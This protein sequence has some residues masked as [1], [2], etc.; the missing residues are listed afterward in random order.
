MTLAIHLDLLVYSL[1]IS[2]FLLIYITKNYSFSEYS[3]GLFAAII[4]ST[5]C[6]L[7][8]EISTWL[9]DGNDSP[10]MRILNYLTNS[11][12]TS[13]EYIPGFFW[14]LYFDYKIIDDF[15]A[16][17]KRAPF[18]LLPGVIILGIVL[19]SLRTGFLFFL[20][21]GNVYTRGPGVY[22]VS[23]IYYI[24]YIIAF[25]IAVRH[26]RNVNAELVLSLVAYFTLPLLAM[27]LQIAFY[28]ATLIWPMFTLVNLIAFI[29]L[30]KDVMLRDPLTGIYTRGEF[31]QKVFRLIKAKKPFTLIMFDLD[32]FKEINDTYGH[33]AGDDA[34]I[35]L[36][37]LVTVE[38]RK[39]DIFCRYG[40]DEF[41]ILMQ[42]D[43]PN[44]GQ[45]LKERIENSVLIRNKSSEKEY[46]LF[47]S[48]GIVHVGKDNES[49]QQKILE[50][51]D[52]QM[53]QE[54]SVNR[55]KHKG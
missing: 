5:S 23:G 22:A 54:K 55:K 17:K 53:Y 2:L 20:Q 26:R 29:L 39:T 3:T 6:V 37:S 7:L 12:L 32:K 19:F 9:V 27:I 13:L 28:G 51:V 33:Q 47:M 48:F 1:L 21:P 38:K 44:V 18:Y 14:L 50:E 16:A 49:S 41:M 43:N 36:V 52:M 46:S 25:F 11:V 10:A 4:I 30:E 42:S 40:G 24:Q 31:Q 45:Y 8:L 34:L 15:E 35:E